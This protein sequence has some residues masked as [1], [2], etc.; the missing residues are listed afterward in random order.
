MGAN[1][2]GLTFSIT[3]CLVSVFRERFLECSS[4]N[5]DCNIGKMTSRG[6]IQSIELLKAFTE[7]AYTT[8]AAGSSRH[9]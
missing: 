6:H 4:L 2:K 8:S 9:L 5:E 1:S 3:K 7:E